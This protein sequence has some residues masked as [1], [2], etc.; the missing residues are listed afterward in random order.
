[1]KRLL[2]MFSLCLYMTALLCG[3]GNA[4][5]AETTA[6]PVETQAATQAPTTEPTEP[7]PVYALQ[8]VYL[9]VQ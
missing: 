5:P 4:K 6:A 7:E 1:M 3:C 8:T 2:A 9:C